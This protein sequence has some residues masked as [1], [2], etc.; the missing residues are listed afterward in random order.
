MTKSWPLISCTETSK[1]CVNV[2]H[3]TDTQSVTNNLK[4]WY[5]FVNVGEQKSI[6]DR[7]LECTISLMSFVPRRLYEKSHEMWLQP[8]C[9]CS[10]LPGGRP[11]V[12]S[13]VFSWYRG[14]TLD[15][16]MNAHRVRKVNPYIMYNG[17]VKSELIFFTYYAFSSELFCDKF[18]NFI[19]NYCLIIFKYGRQNN[20]DFS[21]TLVL[22]LI[23]TSVTC[24][25]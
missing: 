21:T 14:D 20:L 11:Q 8:T 13:V 18:T 25:S 3:Q 15:R 22:Q 17:N 4:Q 5:L 1:I 16:K 12:S 9:F 23:L 2:K 19:R 6:A 10:T 7:G 24:T